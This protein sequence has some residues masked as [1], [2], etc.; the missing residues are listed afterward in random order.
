MPL[1][2]EKEKDRELQEICDF[3][4]ELDFDASV[5][6]KGPWADQD[7]LIVEL[8]TE[9]GPVWEEEDEEP[10]EDLPI[11]AGYLAQLD[12]DSEDQ[13]TKYLMLYF[14]MPKDLKQLDEGMILRTLNDR[15]RCLRMG[16]FFYGEI[17]GKNG[18]EMHIHYRLAI[19]ASTDGGFDEGVVGE[20]I[21]EMGMYYDM[22]L[23]SLKQWE[24][25]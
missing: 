12:P 22:M 13:L 5:L 7:C 4:I 1:L 21:I 18:P 2:S 8:P 25:A 3:L 10:P 23:D 6:P 9:E 16:S 15:N 11:A 14:V 19:G 17:Q 20:A 24:E